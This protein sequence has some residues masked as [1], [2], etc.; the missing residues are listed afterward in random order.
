[1]GV[2]TKVLQ[3]HGKA[4]TV[5]YAAE[6]LM[7]L[8]KGAYLPKEQCCKPEGVIRSIKRLEIAVT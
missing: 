8:Q 4:Y 7:I 5:D 6:N 1:M 3:F 2:V